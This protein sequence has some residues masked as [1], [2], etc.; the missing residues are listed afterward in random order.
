MLL[1]AA[2]FFSFFFAGGSSFFGAGGSFVTAGAA[3]GPFCGTEGSSFGIGRSS[4]FGVDGGGGTAFK[5]GRHPP[6]TRGVRVS[7][8]HEEANSPTHSADKSGTNYVGDTAFKL[9]S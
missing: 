2:Y 5:T 8:L 4:C 6:R 1:S 7:S 3:G 9:T